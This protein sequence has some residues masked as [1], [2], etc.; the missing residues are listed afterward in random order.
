MAE[1]RVG[2]YALV[3]RIGRGGMADVWV[4]KVQGASGFEKVVAIKLLAPDQVD[5][6]EYQRALT[7]EAR[8]QV[9]LRH[10]NIVDVYDL[11]FEAENPYLVM[12]YV[13][14]IELREVLKSLKSRKETLPLS[15][16]AFIVSEIAKALSFAHERCDPET[17]R[18]FHI[19][20]RDVS[21]SNILL[22]VHGDVKLSDFG[23]AKSILQSAATQV[24]QIKGKFRY[25]SPEQ[26]EGSVLDARSDIF[27]LGLV[28]YECL[29]GAPAYEDPSDIGLLQKARTG[30]VALPQNW[31]TGLR[32]LLERLLAPDPRNRYSD[33][34][35]FLREL[36]D[37]L[38][39]TKTE[40]ADR[41]ALAHY[42]AGL[43]IHR[44]TEAASA[45]ALAEQWV[46]EPTAEI[47]DETG[48]IVTLAK[49]R[50][51]R[52]GRKWPWGMGALATVTLLSVLGWMT[53]NER[54]PKTPDRPQNPPVKE[55]VKEEG[56]G[57]LQVHTE[58]SDALLKIRYGDVTLSR[59]APAVLTDVP[60][61][62]SIEVS[63]SQ[64]GYQSAT[65][66][67]TLTAEK[68][69]ESLKLS[70]NEVRGVQVR[71]NA[72][73]YAE[74]TVPGVISGVETPFTRTLPAADYAV[75]F[76][77]GTT[78]KTA[79]ARLKAAG[80]G[81]FLCG[82]NMAVTDPAIPASAWCRAR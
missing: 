54:A 40:A 62:V 59:P 14:G 74:V 33:L 70:L 80:G 8:V 38:R 19:I 37:Y 69:A 29:A 23:I 28:F 75:T 43:K 71:F 1:G 46:P 4:G 20:H 64:K 5:K 36:A 53:L 81:S 73:P 39:Q 60:L 27:S 52:P 68:S 63:A 24:G 32:R 34:K 13:E 22:S 48:R 18:P 11:N 2:R 50:M 66:K 51:L 76:R 67:L 55:T 45:K 82:A 3:K 49:T 9:H 56:L 26:A 17:G 25:M 72:D 79:S 16:G 78:G 31:D 30:H 15:L 35:A 58:P 61:N 7:D 42:L 6:E 44:L 41:E 47:L 10:P 21:P 12:E 57:N 77:H 65:Q